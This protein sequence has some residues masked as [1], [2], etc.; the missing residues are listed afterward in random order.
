MANDIN[1]PKGVG[2]GSDS[3]VTGSIKYGNPVVQ[4]PRKTFTSNNFIDEDTY[5]AYT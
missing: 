2:S 4:A 1:T 3:L 5:S